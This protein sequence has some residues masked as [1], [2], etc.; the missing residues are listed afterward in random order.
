MWSYKS[1][2]QVFG[3][4]ARKRR[5]TWKL[6]QLYTNSWVPKHSNA[7][8]IFITRSL[9][10]LLNK[11]V[12]KRNDLGQYSDYAMGQTIRVSGFHSQQELGIFLFTTV[13]RMVLGPTQHPIQWVLEVKQPGCETDYSLPSSAKVKSAWSYTSTPTIRLNGVVLS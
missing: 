9:T 13:S 12:I 11:H 6:E 8:K 7:N 2:N 1:E 4:A 10:I 3:F 5:V